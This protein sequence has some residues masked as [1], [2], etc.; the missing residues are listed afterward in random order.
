[1][2]TD[3]E[4]QKAGYDA[5]S[6]FLEPVEFERFLVIVKRGNFDYTRWRQSQF[7]EGSIEDISLAAENYSKK[8]FPEQAAAE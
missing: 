8:M 7:Q 4:I 6:R 2:R 1:M 3:N 5:L